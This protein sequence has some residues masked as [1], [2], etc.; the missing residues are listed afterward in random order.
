MG[1]LFITGKNIGFFF[2]FFTEGNIFLFNWT[3]QEYKW[4]SGKYGFL[5]GEI[6]LHVTWWIWSSWN[7]MS[8]RVLE[9]CFVYKKI[10]FNLLD[11]EKTFWLLLTTNA[12]FVNIL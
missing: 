4:L 2:F 9:N 7:R 1:R 12:E 10:C 5:C 11:F 6:S 8:E 3:T